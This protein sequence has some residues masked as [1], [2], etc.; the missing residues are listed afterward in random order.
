M[1]VPSGKLMCTYAVF[2][3]KA[4]NVL[5]SGFQTFLAFQSNNVFLVRPGDLQI[6]PFPSFRSSCSSKRPR[7]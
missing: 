2:P 1:H 7:T 3:V 5:C 4:E 6:L